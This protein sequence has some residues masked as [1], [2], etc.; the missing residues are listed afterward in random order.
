[1]DENTIEGV[2]FKQPKTMAQ[3]CALAKKFHDDFLVNAS[4]RDVALLVD[5]MDNTVELAFEARPEKLVAI[6]NG[7]VVFHT[8]IGPYQYSVGQLERWLAQ[9]CGD[10]SAPN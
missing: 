5:D 10:K 9:E 1:M 7:V 8:G 3:R 4:D 2:C 6:R